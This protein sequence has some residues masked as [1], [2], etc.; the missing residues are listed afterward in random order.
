[1]RLPVSL[2]FFCIAIYLLPFGAR[3]QTPEWWR[4]NVQWDGSTY[5]AEYLITSPRYFG[6]N[7]FTVPA[8]N[9][10]SIDSISSLGAGFN[11][12]FL[13][14]DQTQNLTLYG[15]IAPRNTAISVDVQFIPYERFTVSHALKTR[16]RVYY[17]DY[18]DK[19]A[20][21][22]VIVNTTI[23][24]LK[25]PPET[26]QAAMRV[27]VRMPSGTQMG[28]ARFADMPAYWIDGGFGFPLR[29]KNWKWLLMSGFYVWQ[30]N[31]DKLRQDDAFLF[32]SGLEW[33]KNSWRLQLYGAGY[34]GYKNNGDRPVVARLG[35]EK[36]SR[37]RISFFRLQ[38][39]FFDFRYFSLEAGSRFLFNK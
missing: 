10:G 39:G 16:R 25:R 14:G 13:K 11:A 8:I 3:S 23:R 37:N 31:N 21:G 32:G 1:M 9:N 22:D 33:N 17:E 6:P 19:H 12:H 38:Q 24:L 27:G 2:K 36:K 18:Y 26:V 28:A 7:A 35:L 15:T 5:W 20:T 30:T 34:I 4:N 29:N